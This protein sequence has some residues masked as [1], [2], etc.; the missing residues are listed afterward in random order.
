MGVDVGSLGNPAPTK[1]PT[2]TNPEPIFVSVDT[3]RTMLG[4]GRTAIFAAIAAGEL[5]T[6]KWGRRRLIRV[7]SIQA[8]ADRAVA[9]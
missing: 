7:S 5:E 2:M 1:E 8:L 3:A 9:A 4:I 6:L